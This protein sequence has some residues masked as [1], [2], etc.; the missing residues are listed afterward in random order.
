[1]D[2][3]SNP[4]SFSTWC[5]ETLVEFTQLNAEKQVFGG[6][7][8]AVLLTACVQ[9]IEFTGGLPS[10]FEHLI[11]LPLIFA[12]LLLGPRIGALGGFVTG[13]MLTPLFF[14]TELID[15]ESTLIDWPVRLLMLTL[16]PLIAGLISRSVQ[17]LHHLENKAKKTFQGTALP[18]HEALL[19]QINEWSK[20]NSA[21][22]DALMDIINLRLSNID[23]LRNQV[24]QQKADKIVA[25]L[26]KQLKE[27]LG[28]SA[29]VGQ[30]ATNELVGLHAN[31]EH[32]REELQEKLQQLLS[33]P[34]VID[35]SEFRLDTT[36]GV[37]RVKRES[38]KDKA[39]MVIH[40][41]QQHSYKAAEN[42]Q[43]FSFLDHD[44]DLVDDHEEPLSKQLLSAIDSENIK[45]YYQPRLNTNSG[46]FSVIEAIVRW[47]DNQRGYLSP[48]DFK[49]LIEEA[50]LA[51]QFTGWM[52]KTAF[53]DV[54][55]WMRNDFIVRLSLHITLNDILEPAILNAVAK[56]L[57]KTKFPPSSLSLEV[58]ERS[59][60][61]ISEQSKVYLKKLRSM[62]V[63]IIA[64]QFG[65]GQLTLQ[66]IFVLPVDAIKLSENLV[67]KATSNSDKKRTLISMIKMARSRGLKT[68]ATGV[69]NRAKLLLLK[70]IGCDELQ[71]SILS[72]PTAKDDIPWARIR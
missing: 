19:D 31:T 35:G 17:Q 47:K 53:N 32:S 62:G 26:A 41:A 71:G 38:A 45:L 14:P 23:K 28:Q 30:T 57:N 50:S 59:L 1:M 6:F 60:V 7:L 72:K 54:T 24:G 55:E 44:N 43:T 13:L 11:Y 18:N 65:E 25:E 49:P 2:D 52:I 42:N 70:H 22:T 63:T 58:S 20:Q 15:Q 5:R 69:D 46:Y 36:A 68:I 61:R 29:E 51:K 4:Y 39:N 16:L 40:D 37:L 48:E 27:A 9:L 33:Q 56:S 66:S 12:G 67:L 10:V 34:I 8:I 64:D 21:P 3:S